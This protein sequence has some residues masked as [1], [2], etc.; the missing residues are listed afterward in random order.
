[1]A[2]LNSGDFITQAAAEKTFLIDKLRG[3]LD[4][5]SRKALLERKRDE[6]D[7]IKSELSNV[8]FLIYIA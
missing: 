8:P 2:R 7:F 3:F 4:D 5:T 6:S 1:M